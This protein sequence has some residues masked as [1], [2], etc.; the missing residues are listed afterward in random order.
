MKS[1]PALS[2]PPTYARGWPT[3]AYTATRP[4]PP[5]PGPVAADEPEAG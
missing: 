2:W 4:A 1:R 3:S 5:R